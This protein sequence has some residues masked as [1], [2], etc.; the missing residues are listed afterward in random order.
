MP[1]HVATE[2]FGRY[3]I[4]QMDGDRPD[5]WPTSRRSLT[6]SSEMLPMAKIRPMPIDEFRD[7]IEAHY[8]DRGVT[9]TYISRIRQVFRIAR[10]EA[11]IR[12]TAN[13]TEAGIKRFEA[14]CVRLGHGDRNRLDLL[15][16]L[17]AICGIGVR[18]EL[19]TTVPPFPEIPRPQQLPR[20]GLYASLPSQADIIRFLNHLKGEARTW[21]G[22]RLY[23]LAATIAA[24]GLW[25]EEV[26][27]LRVEDVDLEQ[28]TIRVR[29]REKRSRSSKPS[30]VRFQPELK[31]ILAAWLKIVGCE[32]L[33]PSKWRRGPWDL[34]LHKGRVPIP[35]GRPREPA[36]HTPL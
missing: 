5:F 32:W 9:L 28:G 35:L 26:L 29:G 34:G 18:L 14:A 24:T 33:F 10:D 11:R 31:P 8:Q 4:S 1:I 6:R 3:L 22:C 25:R 30:P 7:A 2:E 23:T 27:A 21:E 15:R 20:V 12:S 16:T 13:L 17:R 36:R 19:L